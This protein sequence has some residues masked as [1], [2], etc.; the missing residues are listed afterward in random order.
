MF[1]R[2]RRVIALVGWVLLAE[3]ILIGGGWVWYATQNDDP[4]GVSEVPNSMMWRYFD[5]YQKQGETIEDLNDEIGKLKRL[6]L[7]LELRQKA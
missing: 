4:L 7:N 6:I 1:R 3:V 2:L 5:Q